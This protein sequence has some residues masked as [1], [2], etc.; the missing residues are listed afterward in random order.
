MPLVLSLVFGLLAKVLL[1][2][3]GRPSDQVLV[4]IFRFFAIMSVLI[5]LLG[6][7]IAVVFRC[8]DWLSGLVA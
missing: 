7:V 6:F 1:S 3:T 4:L 2:A 8:L 5:G